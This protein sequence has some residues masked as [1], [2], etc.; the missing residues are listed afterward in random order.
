[1]NRVSNYWSEDITKNLNFMIKIHKKIGYKIPITYEK[2]C[3]KQ[4][5]VN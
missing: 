1:M 2:E 4:K 5:I 3:Y